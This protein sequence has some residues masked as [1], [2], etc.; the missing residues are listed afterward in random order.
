MAERQP[1][2]LEIQ[3]D[4]N[5]EDKSKSSEA[6][7][8]FSIVS[9]NTDRSFVSGIRKFTDCMCRGERCLSW[10]R[11]IIFPTRASTGF[12]VRCG[13]GTGTEDAGE[14]GKW[15]FSRSFSTERR[16]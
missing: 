13:G 14:I 10:R 3:V 16:E 7:Q 9:I 5:L 4:I 8:M 12:W 11:N 15:D 1:K 6:I 2:F